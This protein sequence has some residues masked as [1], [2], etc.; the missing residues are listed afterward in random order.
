MAYCA[1]LSDYTYAPGFIRPGTKAVGWLALGHA[2]P[3]MISDEETLD[4]LWL[5]CSI[6]VAQTRGGHDCE[7]CPIGSARY[8]ERNGQRLSLGTSE[9]RVFSRDG[10]NYAAPTLIYHYVL[11]HHYKPP[12]EFLQ[13]LR[14]GPRPP[15]KEYFDALA[16]LNL[17]WNRTSRGPAKDR[18]LL[19][20]DACPDGRNYLKTIGT[21]ADI[22]RTGLKFEE[23]L[24]VHFYRPEINRDNVQDDLLFEGTVHL[25]TERDQWYAV[26]NPESYRHESDAP[27]EKPQH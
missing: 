17:E 7:F 21:L 14:E 6:S 23:G 18:I 24:I 16:K 4:L 11:V 10:R 20:P 12:D 3:T 27:S 8:F 5:Y 22:K 13:A 9:I 1:D 19:H 26:I 2:F 15:R 25:D